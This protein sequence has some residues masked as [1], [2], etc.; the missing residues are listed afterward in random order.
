MTNYHSIIN[1]SSFKK[2]YVT[3]KL[4]SQNPVTKCFIIVILK[5]V[6][7]CSSY[8]YLNSQQVHRAHCSYSFLPYI[9]KSN[10]N[11]LQKLPRQLHQPFQYTATMSTAPTDTSLE[12][13]TNLS[14]AATIIA[15]PQGSSSSE[16]PQGPL[17]LEYITLKEKLGDLVDLLAGN[18]PVIT[19]LN[20]HLFSSGLIANAVHI[21]VETIGLPPYNRANKLI[22]AVLA[23]LKSHPDPNNLFTSLITA[24]HKV[25]LI[26]MATILRECFSKCM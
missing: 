1:M 21:A 5:F 3:C 9:V 7:A 17:S 13:S 8:T 16:Q 11:H 20:N 26:T 2:K 22:D 12:G 24:I 23:K 19:P 10:F 25:G 14:A 15:D 6:H 18:A 4:V